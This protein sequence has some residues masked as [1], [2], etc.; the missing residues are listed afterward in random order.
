MAV[1]WPPG[2]KNLP[3]D[4]LAVAAAGGWTPR[5]RGVVDALTES[6][7]LAMVTPTIFQLLRNCSF[8][9][10][11]PKPGRLRA[12]AVDF[13]DHSKTIYRLLLQKLENQLGLL[14]GLRQHRDAGLLQ[15]VGL[16]QLG[17]FGREVRILNRAARLRQVLHRRL[18]VLHGRGEAVLNRTQLTLQLTDRREGRVD[19]IDGVVRT[20]DR[21]HVRIGQRV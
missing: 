14:V 9:S 20:R 16:G 7:S 21:Q 19:G 3:L 18:Q 12:R 8:A 1:E 15:Y 6:A 17:R 5:T 2:G 4:G 10:L 13:L 11:R